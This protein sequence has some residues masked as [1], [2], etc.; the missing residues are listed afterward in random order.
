MKDN[1]V[2]VAY[3]GVRSGVSCA[4]WGPRGIGAFDSLRPFDL[5]QQNKPDTTLLLVSDVLF[6]KDDSILVVTVR[7]SATA[8]GFVAT[9]PTERNGQVSAKASDIAPAGIISA[10]GA[11]AIPR[12]SEIFVS[13]PS[14][15]G[16]VLD[17]DHPQTPVSKTT[18]P[19]QGAICWVGITTDASS[20]ILPDAGNNVLTQ[21][22]LKS[23]KILQQWNSTNGN[24][25]NFDFSISGD[26]KLFA[27]AFNPADSLARVASFDVDGKFKDLD[28]VPIANT[29]NFAQGLATYPV[30]H[31]HEK[32]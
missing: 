8:P 9:Y 27:L 3:D 14:F 20:G 18:V 23:G 11:V 10:F 21:V 22:N 6:A 31:A 26:D 7:G 1:L 5:H 30:D 24:S 32:I 2:C 28:N 16:F 4:S 12:S 29:D 13:D 17:V 15:G 19:G 25:G